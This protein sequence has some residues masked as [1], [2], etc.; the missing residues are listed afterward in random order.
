LGW[1]IYT[2]NIIGHGGAIP[3]YL[4][5]IA[6]KTVSNGKYGIIVML[7]KGSSLAYD[8]HLIYTIFPAIIETLFDEAARMFN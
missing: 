6:F 1:G 8:E 7:N 4:T 3:G 2:D 5:N